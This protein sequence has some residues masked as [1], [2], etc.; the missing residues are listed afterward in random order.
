VSKNRI[1]RGS[2]TERGRRGGGT[3]GDQQIC[4]CKGGEKKEEEFCGD[5]EEF[6][7]EIRR[8]TEQVGIGKATALHQSSPRLHHPKAGDESYQ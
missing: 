5:C 7:E 8:R 2:G 1:K 6:I 4:D 3:V